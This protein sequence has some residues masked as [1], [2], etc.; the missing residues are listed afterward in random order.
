RSLVSD[1]DRVTA[2]DRDA[3]DG[4]AA[5]YQMQIRNPAFGKRMRQRFTAIEYRR[6]HSRVLMY[7]QRTVA[8]IG[9]RNRLPSAAP[10]SRIEMLFF[11]ARR[12]A[13]HVRFD[14]DLQ[15]MHRLIRRIV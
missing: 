9:R 5:T 7:V 1:L 15:K 8:A 3:I 13:F 2:I 12:N 14:P 6:V 10:R 11:V 4:D